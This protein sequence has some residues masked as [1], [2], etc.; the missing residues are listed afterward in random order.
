M[1]AQTGDTRKVAP[2]PDC[3][4]PTARGLMPFETT[5]FLATDDTQIQHGYLGA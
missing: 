1:L 4:L 5:H 3:V 2:C